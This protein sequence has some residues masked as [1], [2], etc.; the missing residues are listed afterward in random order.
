MTGAAVAAIGGATV[1]A[2]A[3]ATRVWINWFCA[4]SLCSIL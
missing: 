2:I 3:G 4:S 1:A